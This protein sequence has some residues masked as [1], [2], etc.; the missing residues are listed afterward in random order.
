MTSDRGMYFLAWGCRFGWH[1]SYPVPVQEDAL[2]FSF[3]VL[4][5]QVL[6]GHKVL[7]PSQASSLALSMPLIFLG[8]ASTVIELRLNE[9]RGL[10]PEIR[11]PGDRRSGRDY[12]EYVGNSANYP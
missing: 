3:V 9:K 11:E 6:H 8:R 2:L 10:I 4:L 12:A 5:N 1:D 7:F